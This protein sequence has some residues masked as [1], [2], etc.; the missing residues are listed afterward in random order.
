MRSTAAARILRSRILR[1]AAVFTASS[2]LTSAVGMVAKALLARSMSPA[3]FGAFSFAVSF[4]MF[5]G[6]FF[7]FGVFLP[8]AR[9]AALGGAAERRRVVGAA[10]LLFVPVGIACSLT[11][12]ALSYGVDSWFHVH[13]GDAL[14][15]VAPFAFLY[16]FTQVSLPLSQGLDRLN[17]WSVSGVVG[18][19]LFLGAIAVIVAWAVVD[20]TLLLVLRAG[21]L[22][23]A[24]GILVVWLRPSF[25]E[26]MLHARRLAGDARAYGFQVYVGRM[27]S[28][29]TYQMDVLMLAA[30]SNA[31][32]VGFYALAGAVSYALGLPVL[33]MATALF[34]QLAGATELRRRWILISTGVGAAALLGALVL[35][36]PVIT[37]VFSDRYAAAAALVGPLVAAEAVRGVTSVYNT[38]LSAQGRGRELRNAALVLTCSNVVL[39]IAL[40]PSFGAMGAAW[41]SLLAL[42]ANL[43]AHVVVYE[44]SQ[45][46]AAAAAAA[47]AASVPAIR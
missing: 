10:L 28:I 31:T 41:A 39:N 36:R 23:V 3:E 9:M 13:V 19:L 15:I 21:G 45:R 25:R 17:A 30:Y 8:A 37:L 1:Q 33:G 26:P 29:G 2:V 32:S 46:R 6:L 14:R 38:Y 40:I 7:D 44:R 18:Q 5:V 11:V 16:A 43:L 20:V 27:L 34:P 12:F 47:A 4:L 24:A 42:G 22:L 35:A